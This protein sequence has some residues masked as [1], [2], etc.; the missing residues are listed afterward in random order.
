MLKYKS[1]QCCH[2]KCP[3]AQRELFWTIIIAK[4]KRY[5]IEYSD[6][7][8]QHLNILTNYFIKSIKRLKVSA[9]EVSLLSLQQL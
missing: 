6:N 5:T 4:L 7:F 2:C 3:K 1:L 8:N 9:V